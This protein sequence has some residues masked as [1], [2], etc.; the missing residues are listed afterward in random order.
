MLNPIRIVFHQISDKVEKVQYINDRLE[1]LLTAAETAEEHSR[2]AY[3]ISDRHLAALIKL[4]INSPF[5]EPKL[6]LPEQHPIMSSNQQLIANERIQC[7]F[8]T[9]EALNP[10][11]PGEQ[12]L[13]QQQSFLCDDYLG[14]P[15][16]TGVI[17]QETTMARLYFVFLD[18]FIHPSGDVLWVPPRDRQQKKL[19]SQAITQCP[20]D[21]S[22]KQFL[23]QKLNK[24]LQ[25]LMPVPYNILAATVTNPL[26]DSRESYP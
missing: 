22:D 23:E 13:S 15:R 5:A 18:C 25:H 14:Y 1:L 6:A 20:S 11:L 2:K 4:V 19:L 3:R 16:G 26:S 24:G 21:A 12:L 7:A 8:N 10:L 9:I 17:K